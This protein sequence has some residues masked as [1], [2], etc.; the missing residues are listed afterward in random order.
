MSY[1][2][3]ATISSPGISPAFADGVPGRV[4]STITRPGS[5]DT[6]L[7]K[8]FCVELFHLLE[9]VELAGV[10]EDRMRI[11][12]AQQTREWLPGTSA[13]SEET[14]SAAFRSTAA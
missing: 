10:E 11:E 13:C 9:L 4:C 5:S 3:I 2:L 1:P 8:P 14:G 12:R 7:P 6:T